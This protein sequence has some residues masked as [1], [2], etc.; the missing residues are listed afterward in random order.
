MCRQKNGLQ[1]FF[2]I[3]PTPCVIFHDFFFVNFPPPSLMRYFLNC[4]LEA[5]L[6]P[7][8][9]FHDIFFVNF[10]PPSLMRYFLNCPLEAHLEP[11]QTPVKRGYQARKH[12]R[13]LRTASI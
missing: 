7:C 5:H 6:E 12:V 11:C 8:V 10:P 13:Y 9:S 3:T 2:G 4:P 1:N